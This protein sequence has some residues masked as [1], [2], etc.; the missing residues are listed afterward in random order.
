M[1][2]EN[3]ERFGLS[4][5]HQ[6]RGRVGRGAHQSYCVLIAG[7]HSAAT[8]KRL[9][10][11]EDSTDGFVIAEADLKLRGPGELRGTRQSGLDD[12]KL[13]DITRDAEVIQRARDFARAI[14][15]AD[16]RL[17]SPARTTLRAE[18]VARSEQIAVRDVI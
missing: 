4:Q 16:P 1:V 15:D 2:I 7:E 3:A 13:G 12:L 17:E 6:L 9:K 11:I 18:L 5:L 10:V 8:R 14:L